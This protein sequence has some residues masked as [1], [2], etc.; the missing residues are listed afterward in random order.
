MGMEGMKM[1]MKNYSITEYSAYRTIFGSE[2]QYAVYEDI[3]GTKQ[4]YMIA[5]FRDK[6]E[7]Y[8]YVVAKENEAEEE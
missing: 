1:K 8:E 4:S 3:E 6:G 2:K 7:A 5:M